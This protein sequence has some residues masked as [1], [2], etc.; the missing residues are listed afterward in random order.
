[1]IHIYHTVSVGRDN[2]IRNHIPCSGCNYDL[3]GI[4]IH[5][6]CPEC[7][8]SMRDALSTRSRAVRKE[9]Q[10]YA[11][12]FSLLLT[13]FGGAIFL[14]ILRSRLYPRQ[15]IPDWLHSCTFG[16]GILALILCFYC[17]FLVWQRR[18]FRYV[19]LAAVSLIVVS[20]I[21]LI[22]AHPVNA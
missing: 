12:V 5:G 18:M 14:S 8:L 15:P 13:C 4:S 11:I 9:S 19:I 1:M 20:I 22:M 3:I 21:T 6:T 17:V 16:C 10:Q 2:R 7:G